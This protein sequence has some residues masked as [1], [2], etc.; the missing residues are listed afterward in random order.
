MSQNKLSARLRVESRPLLAYATR[1][2]GT[3][4]AYCVSGGTWRAGAAAKKLGVL[5]A[6]VHV[7]LVVDDI[8]VA[9]LVALV[10]TSI[11]VASESRRGPVAQFL[12][13]ELPLT[14]RRDDRIVREAATNTLKLGSL[15]TRRLGPA[16]RKFVRANL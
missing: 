10:Q 8:G 3:R 15:A 7:L 12:K 5:D 11:L 9:G 6:G 4:R 14:S 2:R 1:S 13:I 16:I